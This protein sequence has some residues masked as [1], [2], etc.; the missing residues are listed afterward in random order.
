M[1][2]EKILRR[3][4]LVTTGATAAFP[5]LIKS[6]LSHGSLQAFVNH[7]FTHITYQCGESLNLFKQWKPKINYDLNLKAFDFN[8]RGLSDEMKRCKSIVG[9]SEAGLVI[10][11]A[12]AGTIL[13]ALRYGIP[14]I[15]VPND[16]L[17]DNHQEELAEEL[18]RQGYATKST[19]GGLPQAIRK[20]CTKEPTPWAGHNASLAPIINDV[21][22]YEEDLKAQLD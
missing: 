12:G 10:C 6:A 9:V 17:M 11:H 14:L 13:E 5:E 20:A 3:E 2:E 1:S 8:Q 7:K 4:C 18:D 21:V 22:G 19:I 16:T 15:V